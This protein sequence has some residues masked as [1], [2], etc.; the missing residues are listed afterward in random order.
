MVRLKLTTRASDRPAATPLR[1]RLWGKQTAPGTRGVHRLVMT[2]YAEFA[3]PEPPPVDYPLKVGLPGPQGEGIQHEDVPLAVMLD[4]WQQAPSSTGR[5]FPLVGGLATRQGAAGVQL[6]RQRVK[7]RCQSLPT[8]LQPIGVTC[9][10]GAYTTSYTVNLPA[11]VLPGDWLYLIAHSS[12]NGTGN[13]SYSAGWTS[14]G[15]SAGTFFRSYWARKQYAAGDPATVT[16]TYAA[17]TFAMGCLFALRGATRVDDTSFPRQTTTA[18]TP[19]SYTGL[20]TTGTPHLTMGVLALVEGVTCTAPSGFTRLCH[21]AFAGGTLVACYKTGILT[22]SDPTYTYTP[23][24]AARGSV[25]HV[26]VKYSGAS[27]P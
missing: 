10:A 8:S 18:T 7:V 24:A 2:P 21:G 4:S 22:A 1:A 3:P 11:G 19:L 9:I 16:V 25:Y 6:A 14:V 13:P 17:G 26:A 20:T 23:S 12:P 27:W 15:N 5:A